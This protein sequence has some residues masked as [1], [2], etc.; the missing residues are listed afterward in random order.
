[1]LILEKSL[2]LR[3]CKRWENDSN[4][5]PHTNIYNIFQVLTVLRVIHMILIL[6]CTVMDNSLLMYQ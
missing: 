4:D 3:K 1:M 5:V 6:V 2:L